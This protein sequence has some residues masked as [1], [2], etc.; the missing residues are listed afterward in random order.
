MLL[1]STGTVTEGGRLLVQICTS[2]FT[3]LN[4]NQRPRYGLCNGLW[5]GQVPTELQNL[6][7]PEQLLIALNFPRCFVFK[8]HPKVRRT[9]DPSTLQR[10]MVGNV[11]SFPLNTREIIEMIQGQTNAS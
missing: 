9:C 8:M 11:T 3:Q 6:S 2:C 1:E 4:R 10:G 5:L 7:I